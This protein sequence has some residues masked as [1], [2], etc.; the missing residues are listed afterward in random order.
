[1]AE[2]ITKNID[3]RVTYS[4]YGS[5]E[6]L[7]IAFH[8][9]GMNGDQFNVLESS[10]MK[11][12]TIIGFH[13]PY[14]RL[15]PDTHHNWIDQLKKTIREMV[16]QREDNQFSLAGYSIGCKVCLFLLRDFSHHISKLFLF[17]PYGIEN[18][19]G[20][21]CISKGFGHW[22]FKKVINSPVPQFIMKAT[23]IL[24]VID[25]THDYIIQKEIDTTIKRHNLCFSLLFISE[26][27]TNTHDIVHILNQYQMNLTLVYGQK[28][29][30][31]PYSKRNQSLLSQ[32]SNPKVLE[33]IEGHWMMTQ[34]LDVLLANHLV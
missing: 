14:H 28:D 34:K 2:L 32:I 8:G 4:T 11:Q 15:G 10:L 21:D 24:G 17:A 30:L 6:Q 5:G 3:S 26:L 29:V 25:H 31:F 23:R 22:F 27:T 18:H 33:V 20:I 1:M 7:L 13:L 9:Y 19:W 16:S 12:Y